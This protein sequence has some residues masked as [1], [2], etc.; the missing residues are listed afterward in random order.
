MDQHKEAVKRIQKDPRIITSHT[1]LVVDMSA[2]MKKS[3][4]NG[5]KTRAKGV[6]YS[7]AEEFV[8]R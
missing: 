7:L 6:Y 8:A 2:S 4:M 5:H 1:A 3:D